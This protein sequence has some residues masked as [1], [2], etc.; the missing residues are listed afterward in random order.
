MMSDENQKR[1]E[2]A[3]N[4]LRVAL[5]DRVNRNQPGRVGVVVP[6][7]RGKFGNVRVIDE[8]DIDVGGR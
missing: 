1:I 4:A 2:T 3:V 6:Y 7:S 8:R 5:E